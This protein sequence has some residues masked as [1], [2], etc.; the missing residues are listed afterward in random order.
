MGAS[1]NPPENC[2]P[3]SFS[4]C[5]AWFSPPAHGN[6]RP[7]PQLFLFQLLSHLELPDYSSITVLLSSTQSFTSYCFTIILSIRL[8][9]VILTVPGLFVGFLKLNKTEVF[10][11]TVPVRG[12]ESNTRVVIRFLALIKESRSHLM[13]TLDGCPVQIS[14]KPRSRPNQMM[15]TLCEEAFNLKTGNNKCHSKLSFHCVQVMIGPRITWR[16]WKWQHQGATIWSCQIKGLLKILEVALKIDASSWNFRHLSAFKTLIRWMEISLWRAEHSDMQWLH[17]VGNL[18]QIAFEN[19]CRVLI[20][21]FGIRILLEIWWQGCHP[22][23]TSAGA[24]IL[25]KHLAEFLYSHT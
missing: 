2:W 11:I 12:V 22:S 5:T 18:G 3:E 6:T 10:S 14:A 7:L 23:N 13:A 4:L 9:G 1:C 25:C 21:I 17:L 8:K 16:A 24:E 15:K 19:L 20:C